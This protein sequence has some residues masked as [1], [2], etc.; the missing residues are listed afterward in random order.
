MPSNDKPTVL[1]AGTGAIGGY[2]GGKLAQAGARISALCR[3]DYDTVKSSGIQV[4]SPGGDFHFRPDPVVRNASELGFFPDYILVALKVLPAVDAASIIRGAVGPETSILLI[5]NGIESEAAV[6]KAFP[7]NEIISA[8]GFI[9]VSR[10]APG[11]IRHQDFGK[12]GFGHYPSGNSDKVALLADLFES[13]GVTC[14]VTDDVVTARWRKLV[15]NAPFNPISV[16]AGG[17]DTKTMLDDPDSRDLVRAVME[18]VC[19]VAASTGHPLP[20]SVVDENIDHTLAMTPY[21]TSM[22]LDF[23]AGRPLEV[24]AILGKAV[25]V[26]RE[27]GVPAP[28]M[29]TL[30]A[31]LKMID[32]KNRRG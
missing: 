9:C 14:M 21:K 8:L 18:E 25:R 32:E 23:E 2:Y 3:S 22:L 1:I 19:A 20:D 29:E 30:H 26:A 17:A 11:V 24:E 4:T 5:Q 15:W 16:L 6:A 13:V 28:R 27:N 7:E 10:E 31:L 12:L